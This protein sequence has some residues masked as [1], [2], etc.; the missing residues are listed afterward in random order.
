MTM[1]KGKATHKH[2]FSLLELVISISL[3]AAVAL[4]AGQ[5]SSTGIGVF[6][7]SNS[8]T[9]LGERAQRVLDRIGEE[10]SKT[11]AGFYFPDPG[12]ELG[13]AALSFQQV[14]GLTGTEA[15]WGPLMM[16]AFE[17]ENGEINNGADDNGNGLID[18]GV[19]VMTQDVGGA[20]QTRVV[21]CHGVSEFLAGEIS[22][23]EDDNGN[24]LRDEEG[25]SFQRFGN[26]MTIYLT[27]ELI[28]RD[29]NLIQ[30]TLETSVRLRN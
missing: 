11:G 17:Y 13:T 19:V 18:E 28:D 9:I 27:V 12:E 14:T 15:D 2:G 26:M 29:G 5:V 25:L 22:N 10:V 4:M 24:I 16:I 1:N 3:L 20:E 7:A 23:G 30:R 6:N 8:Q 21:L